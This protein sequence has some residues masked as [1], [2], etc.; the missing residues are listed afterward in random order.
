MMN[1]KRLLAVYI[2]FSILVSMVPG[3]LNPFVKDVKAAG[4][5]VLKTAADSTFTSGSV[6][7]YW[8]PVD[9]ATSYTISY[10]DHKKQTDIAIDDASLT[11][12]ANR[13]SM[14]ITGLIPDYVYDFT[15][16]A[17][18]TE[19]EIDEVIDEKQK[20]VITGITFTADGL[21]Q[22]SVVEDVY[23]GGKEAGF[24]P[25]MSFRIK[26]PKKLSLSEDPTVTYYTY[27]V[28]EELDYNIFIGTDTQAE[29]MPSMKLRYSSVSSSYILTRFANSTVKTVAASVNYATE[30]P[31]YIT[32][33]VLGGHAGRTEAEN[34]LSIGVNPDYPS[35]SDYGFSDNNMD[36]FDMATA[37]DVDLRNIYRNP[38]LKPGVI[39][40]MKAA[41]AFHELTG[42]DTVSYKK[43]DVS[44]KG[45]SF[46]A[47]RF[48]IAKD[49]SNNL[50][51]TIY[52]VNKAAAGGTSSPT[53][54]YE[55]QHSTSADFENNPDVA[56]DARQAGDIARNG[57][58][59][60]F[61]EN[62]NPDSILYY[63][64][65]V[66]TPS[67]TEVLYSQTIRYTPSVDTTLAP[68]P[69]GLKVVKVE[70]LKG[71]VTDTFYSVP[72]SGTDYNV[73]TA[74]V[75][76]VWKKPL[77]YTQMLSDGLYYYF[78][79]A[80]V[81]SPDNQKEVIDYIFEDITKSREYTARYREIIKLNIAA[82]IEADRDGTP[83][84]GGSYLMY[85][86]DGLNLF[87]TVDSVD[88]V[89][90]SYEYTYSDEL[91]NSEPGLQYKYPTYLLPNRIYYVRAYSQREDDPTRTSGDSLTTSFTT[92]LYIDKNPAAP[93][94]FG[95]VDNSITS[96][97]K[98]SVTLKWDKI[99]SAQA[100]SVAGSVYYSVHYDLYISDKQ[101][102]DYVE[103][104]NVRT[105]DPALEIG[106]VSFT[107]KESSSTVINA[108]ISAIKAG[109]DLRERFGDS[110]KPNFTYYFKVR[111]RIEFN[112]VE[113]NEV[114]RVSDLS[115]IL[116][117]TTKRMDIVPPGPGEKNPRVP[118]NFGIAKD[119]GGNYLVDGNSATLTWTGVEEDV[120]YILIRT[121]LK[122]ANDAKLTDI[123]ANAENRM[124]RYP[125]STGTF[126]KD[127]TE[128]E[129]FSY[130][131]ATKEFLYKASDLD[132]NYV[133]YFSIRAEKDIDATTILYSHWLTVPVTTALI[134][135]PQLLNAIPRH[136][137]GFSW[138][139]SSLF[140]STD[141][142]VASA[143]SGSSDYTTVK[144]G[145]VL[146]SENKGADNASTFFARVTSL[147]ANTE[148]DFRVT[149]STKD[150]MGNV[151]P[152]TTYTAPGI[153]TRDELYAVDVKWKGRDGYGFEL[154]IKGETDADYRII[155]DTDSGFEYTS[156]GEKPTT[157]AGTDYSMNYARISGLKSNT[158]YY[159][160]VRSVKT[161]ANSEKVYSKYVG[162]VT[163]RTEFS[164][165]DRDD[166]EDD[167]NEETTYSDREKRFNEKLYWVMEKSEDNLKIKIRADRAE[168]II[169]HGAGNLSLDL[170]RPV[171]TGSYYSAV[172]VPLKT[173]D[174]LTSRNENL[175]IRTNG[176]E[177]TFRPGSIDKTK[178][179][180]LKDLK[181]DTNILEIY[182]YISI[183]R[184]TS[185]SDYFPDGTELASS[186]L[187]LDIE[188]VGTSKTETEIENGFKTKIK[189]LISTGLQTLKDT[190]K[191]EKDTPKKLEE[192]IASLLD[193][194]EYS[195]QSYVDDTMEE[196]SSVVYT[197]ETN[198]E[199]QKPVAVKMSTK[200]S[201]AGLTSG[202]IY[203]DSY[204]EWEEVKPSV[205]TAGNTVTFSIVETGELALLAT[206]STLLNTMDE[207]HWAKKDVTSLLSKI[208]MSN[209][210]GDDESL[211]GTVTI[212]QAVSAIEIILVGNSTV[213]S[214]NI[215]ADKVKS[216]GMEGTINFNSP[217]RKLLRQEMAA[218][219]VRLYEKKTGASPGSMKPSKFS[220]TKDEKEIRKSY[221]TPV[222]ICIEKGLMVLD[223][224]SS[225][226]PDNGATRAEL[227]AAIA[228]MLK[229]IGEL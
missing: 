219:I 161:A 189:E 8:D 48:Q 205:P 175:I 116:P 25:Q 45:Y 60:L 178:S 117:V 105:T 195:M 38:D 149:G 127:T 143:K 131:S 31:G 73:Q 92:P 98:N 113:G 151:V 181:D 27:H 97:G 107:G 155:T 33:K 26:I 204:Y 88:E 115:S 41:P 140:E 86:L 216:L 139:A 29:N 35:D 4:T 70:T 128:L 126:D 176:G 22:E 134:E 187:K 129:G 3:N 215:F 56:I 220:E 44:P 167:T 108:I 183:D 58:L 191:D 196:S 110:I 119:S 63:R 221:Y 69:E 146:I 64:V 87:T 185:A 83:V 169:K 67:E 18:K 39:Y 163:A 91:P 188:S 225:F 142:T 40:Y 74:K 123:E 49:S 82:C 36:D 224:N 199:F 137:A 32:F 30:E 207:S 47:V 19:D 104:G 193:D 95:L 130:N 186:V 133:Y 59:S 28:P 12:T 177:F 57:K 17:I 85:E 111:T 50:I 11:K 81:Q 168:N 152:F 52:E 222:Q 71:A 78:K 227:L 166:E 16:Q 159:I 212:S 180:I 68:I 101:L 80:S 24:E 102:D 179:R 61:I 55:V 150:S 100:Q 226:R 106:D 200:T 90:S 120:K 46:T 164:Q 79:I 23:G 210:F 13:I 144:K 1:F 121:S 182:A 145:E 213:V 84:A 172:Y 190:A 75:R 54:T 135:M 21:N 211:E 103:I 66:Y 14:L 192:K 157:L 147:E 162:P 208:Y 7:L 223:S 209:V 170:S 122:I 20:S 153:T 218:I 51:A 136:E 206:E 5:L 89:G 165:S 141:F 99:T 160:K 53:F 194:I 158:K 174:L 76:F 93:K 229:A 114:T 125:D 65:K 198:T 77:N 203:S 132:P 62:K 10:F 118:L 228:R 173:I 201:I 217:G 214:T 34:A 9:G 15:V 72:S 138:E 42:E 154:A 124:N 184:I 43:S 197:R 148:Y 96:L 171:A 112:D 94:S 109:S 202:Y 6:T 2:I 37:T 156:E